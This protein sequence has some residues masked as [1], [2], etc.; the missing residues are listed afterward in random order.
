MKEFRGYIFDVDGVILLGGEAIEGSGEAIR[1]LKGRGRKVAVVS[2]NSTRSREDYVEKMRE[3]DLPIEEEELIPATSGTAQ[4]LRERY[5]STK[6]FPL[7]GMGLL[8][9]LLL[10]GLKLVDDPGKAELL[11]TGTDPDLNYTRLRKATEILLNGAPWV[12]CNT[13]RLYPLTPQKL[14]P[15]TGLVV[16][17][18]SYVTGREPDVVIGKPST[19]LMEQALSSMGISRE[20]CLVV[21]DILDTD[22]LAGK[23]AAISTALVLTGVTTR[24]EAEKSS[25]QPDYIIQSLEELVGNK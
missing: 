5:A 10:A 8:K 14:I 11:V 19:P 24:E 20:E 6:I 17:A 21:G 22:I 9:E 12:T 25:I 3:N 2:N 16:G 1:S 18:L 7:G 4:Y 13:D 23:N 15:G